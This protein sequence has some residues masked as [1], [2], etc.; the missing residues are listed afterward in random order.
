ME[1]LCALWLHTWDTAMVVLEPSIFLCVPRTLEH[2]LRANTGV[3]DTCRSHHIRRHQFVLPFIR[4]LP[5]MLRMER[6]ESVGP[7]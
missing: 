3:N 1:G 2:G 5:Y 6:S 4:L 7:G